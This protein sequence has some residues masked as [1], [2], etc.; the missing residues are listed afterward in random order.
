MSQRYTDVQMKHEEYVL[1][2]E[3]ETDFNQIECDA[4]MDAVDETFD[5]TEKMAC[6][7][8]T[9][10]GNLKVEKDTQQSDPVILPPDV[11]GEEEQKFYNLREFEKAELLNEIKKVKKLLENKEIDAETFQS[12]LKD[13]QKDLKSQLERCRNAQAQFLSIIQ[14]ERVKTG[15]K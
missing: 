3:E 11:K 10:K 15:K 14:S 8:L 13:C 2:I 12:I 1:S 5:Q 7:Y 9:L 6:D 4:W